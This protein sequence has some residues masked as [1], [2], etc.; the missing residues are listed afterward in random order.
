[1][2]R[3]ALLVV[4]ALG[5]SPRPAAA[6]TPNTVGNTTGNPAGDTTAIDGALA[7]FAALP[8]ST[9]YVIEAERTPSP[10]RAEHLP[11]APMFVG[12]AIKTFILA[13]FLREMEAGRLSEDE[14]LPIDDDI[15]SLSSPVFLHLT[16]TTTA[17]SVL[18]AM[19]THSDNTATDVAL[20][21]IG[22]ERVRAFITTAGLNG[23][24]IPDSTRRLF[25][26]LAGADPGVDLG[27]QGMQQAM[28]GKLP[29]PARSPINDRQS[30]IC[31]AATFVGYY[32]QALQGRY[33]TKPATLG[34]FKRIQAMADAIALVVPPDTVAYAKG[35]SIDWRDFLALCVAGQMLLGR[36]PVT[37]CFTLNWTG[38]DAG[39]A[40]AMQGFKD[41][42]A[43]VLAAVATTFG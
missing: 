18:E 28:D 16:G 10:W 8:G 30:M 7:R 1:L 5:L 21:R 38:P 11:Q 3:R 42:V 6:Q 19:I 39:V 4:P 22:V 43:G 13:T 23:I 12:S 35:G 24:L 34:E 33:F 20:H 17:R 36:R 37:F 26:Y 41:S 40:D 14:Q 31:S 15:R 9:S 32:Q 25:S 27:W 29:G 2:H